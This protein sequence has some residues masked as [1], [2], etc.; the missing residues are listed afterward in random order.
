M[1]LFLILFFFPWLT[2]GVELNLLCTNNYSSYKH[3][4]VKDVFLLLD[5][6][7]KEINLGGLNFFADDILIT[8]SN[9]SWSA[10]DVNLYPES[11]G[12]ISGIIGRYSGELVLNF[13]KDDD[14]K[15]SSL[16]FNCRKFEMK[17]RK[18]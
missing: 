10:S 12:K 5:S 17:E 11:K 14:D 16:V 3:V 6:N 8:K 4:D 2:F 9:I 18:F 1:Y 7:S 15:L 13:I